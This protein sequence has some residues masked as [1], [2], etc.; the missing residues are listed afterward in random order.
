MARK[1]SKTGK[2]IG[3]T[4]RFFWL[5]TKGGAK[6]ICVDSFR[7]LKDSYH[8]AKN[9]EK[10]MMLDRKLEV[11]KR[12]DHHEHRVNRMERLV[13]SMFNDPSYSKSNKG[14]DDLKELEKVVK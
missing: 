11:E 5:V 10:K 4:A 9:P 2:A 14:Q 1:R 12:V 8:Y 13:Y 3:K 7:V 6:L